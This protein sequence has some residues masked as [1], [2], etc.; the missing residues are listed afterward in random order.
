MTRVYR[1]TRKAF[2]R[3]P[4]DGEGS[5]RY[6]GRWSS[7]GTRIAYTAAHQ[8]LAM[9]EYLAHLDPNDVPDD[10]VL[11]Q[12]DIPDTVPRKWMDRSRLREGWDMYPAPDAL[13][14]YGDMFVEDLTVAIF[15]VPSAL[16]PSE[17]NWLINPLHRSFKEIMV[18]PL[19]S[20]RYDRRLLKGLD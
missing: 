8:S 9:L 4:F 7:P 14:Q 16:V 12:A 13:Q 5:Y 17:C 11:A 1:L 3:H 15:I 10:L 19:Q 20:I 6:G 18:Q 2:A